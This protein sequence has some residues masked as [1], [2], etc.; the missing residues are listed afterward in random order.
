MP[1]FPM[2]NDSEPTGEYLAPD[3]FEKALAAMPETLRP[4]Y[5]FLYYTGCRLG[6]AQAITWQMVSADA[7]EIKIPGPLMKSKN[8]LTIVLAG[9]GLEPVSRLLKKMFRKNGDRVFDATNYRYE[10][11][12]ASHAAGVVVRDSKR[13]TYKGVRIHDL[14]ISA[15]VNLIDAGVPQDIVMKIGVVGQFDSST[16]STAASGTH[17]V[18]AVAVV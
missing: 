7:T 6:A 16:Q 14:R 5:T 1:Y 2:P 9:P 8:P 13:R 12:K 17:L 10:W 18:R 3:V 15:A 4:F 11:H